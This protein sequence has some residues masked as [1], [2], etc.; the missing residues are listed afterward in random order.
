M[1]KPGPKFSLPS[2][3][4]SCPFL[5]QLRP[6]V[7]PHQPLPKPTQ[8]HA[9]GEDI[10]GLNP[11]PAW[12]WDTCPGGVSGFCP[13][14]DPEDL[15]S[16]LA[17]QPLMP[18]VPRTRLVAVGELWMAPCREMEP[19]FVRSHEDSH[20]GAERKEHQLDFLNHSSLFLSHFPCPSCS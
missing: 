7:S 19:T 2:L 16:F 18:P 10:S 12:A 5:P 8:D 11:V 1:P 6:A 4:T 13:E 14:L 9:L 15:G 20:C 3:V 17:L